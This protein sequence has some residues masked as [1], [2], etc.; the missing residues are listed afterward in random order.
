MD[1]FRVVGPAGVGLGVT[2]LDVS[3]AK[4][5]PPLHACG[6]RRFGPWRRLSH[7]LARLPSRVPQGRSK[8]AF[9]AWSEADGRASTFPLHSDERVET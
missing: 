9:A 2:R 7:C 5:G 4:P 6:H 1:A 3:Q 8:C